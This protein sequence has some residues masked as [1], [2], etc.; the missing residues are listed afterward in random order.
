HAQSNG[1]IAE[2]AALDRQLALIEQE[3]DVQQSL[4]AKGLARASAVL[5]LQREK[6]RLEGQ[7]GELQAELARTAG[8]ITETRIEISSLTT[9]RREAAADEL[10]QI[11]PM[12]LELEERRRALVGRIDRLELRAPVAG[13]VLGLQ[14]T[15]PRSVLRPADP[16]L[17]IIPQDRPLVITAHI[18]LIHIDEVA[19]GQEAELVF[20]AFAARE[21]PHLRGRITRISADA[22]T[23]PRTGT[24]YYSAEVQL[25]DDQS[26]RLG[27]RTIVPGMPVEVFLQT[28]RYTPLAYLLKPFTDYFS[29]AFRET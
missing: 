6:A 4:L 16:V 12:L 19:P 13:I 7:I 9:K 20:P 23:D 11:G 21:T 24:G 28:G 22:Q 25:S 29:H 2:A 26:A 17:Y 15:T 8:Q 5:A 10:R 27:D 3:L 14:V 18:A 1:I